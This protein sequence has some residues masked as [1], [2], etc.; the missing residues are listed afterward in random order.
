MPSPPQEGC[1]YLP[2]QRVTPLNLAR[3]FLCHHEIAS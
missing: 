3:A 2:M 1:A